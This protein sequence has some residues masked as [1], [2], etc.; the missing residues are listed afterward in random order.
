MRTDDDDFEPFEVR[1]IIALEDTEFRCDIGL[2]GGPKG[3]QGITGMVIRW[4]QGVPRN[5]R[6]GYQVVSGV[7][8]NHRYG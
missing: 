8:I 5:R 7:P 6:Y 4:C 3:Y 1:P 2:S